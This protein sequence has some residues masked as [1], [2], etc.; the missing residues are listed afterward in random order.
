MLMTA[1][2]AIEPKP[3]LPLPLHE[4][5]ARDIFSG[6]SKLAEF[7]FKLTP[8]L[9]LLVTFERSLREDFFADAEALSR[10][11]LSCGRFFDGIR[12]S[13]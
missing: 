6:K 8:V 9:P 1:G 7:T 2:P 12:P 3:M 11:D 5:A 10:C 4:E 13:C